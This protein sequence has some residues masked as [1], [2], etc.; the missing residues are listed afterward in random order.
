MLWEF[1]FI[2]I[3]PLLSSHYS[4]S[5]GHGVPFFGGFQHPFVND[6]S[7]H[8]C[9]FLS[10]PRRSHCCFL[11]RMQVSQEMSKVV[12]YSHLFKNFPWFVLSHTI[13]GFS[14]VSEAKINLSL[15]LLPCFLHYS[16]ACWQFDLWFLCLFKTQLIHLEFFSSC[17]A[18]A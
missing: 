5:V 4:F 12:W 3:V 16:N 8:S 18:L 1:D 10:S 7:K 15:E 9:D 11:T 14:I 2:V 17:T 6:C 13:K